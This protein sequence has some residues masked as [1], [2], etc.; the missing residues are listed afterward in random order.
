MFR[1][2]G[3]FYAVAVAVENRG[4]EAQGV[5]EYKLR[6]AANAQG[7]SEYKLRKAAN[8]Q[9]VSE[10]KLRKAAN[11][12]GVLCRKWRRRRQCQT[13]I[14]RLVILCQDC[15]TISAQAQHAEQAAPAQV[16]FCAGCA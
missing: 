1:A 11:A 7:V 14:W 15:H 5:S 3:A 6:K 4:L 16:Y 13:A 12:K 10:H 2:G 8:A 9:G